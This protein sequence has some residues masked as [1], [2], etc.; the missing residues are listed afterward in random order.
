[1]NRRKQETYKR[2][3][4]LLIK[5]EVQQAE[6]EIRRFLDENV[7]DEVGLNLLSHSLLKQN[8][9]DKAM[10]MFK[11]IIQKYPNS[12]RA[13][14]DLG[15]LYD[16][17]GNSKEAIKSYGKALDLEPEYSEIWHFLGNLLM[18]K[19]DKEQGLDCF[20][21][22]FYYDPYQDEIRKMQSAM[23]AQNIKEASIISAQVLERHNHHPH[24]LTVMADIATGAGAHQDAQKMLRTGLDYSPYNLMLWF[25]LVSALGELGHHEERIE[26]AQKLFELEPELI[27][28]SA[29]LGDT[30]ANAGLYDKALEA[31]AHGLKIDNKS[32]NTLLQYG[33]MLK[34]LGRREEC[35]QAYRNC[36]KLKNFNGAV[37]WALADL[38]NS[39]F[40]AKD[41]EAMHDIMVDGNSPAAQA[42]QAGFALGKSYE[43]MQDFDTAFEYYA[44]ANALKPKVMFDVNNFNDQNN[45]IIKTF[46]QTALNKKAAQNSSPTP[47]FIIGL[48]RAG[49][50]LVEQILASHSLI[51]GTKELD[52]LPLIFKTINNIGRTKAIELPETIKSLSEQDLC[53][54]GQQYLDDTAIYRSGKPYFIDKLPSNFRFVGLIHMIL[55]NAIIF[56]VRRHPLD[57]GFSTYKQHFATGNDFSYNLEHIGHYYNSYLKLM[58]Y[59]DQV[60]PGKVYCL[61]YE[62]LVK[63]TEQEVQRLLD[64][65]GL[66]FEKNCLN[67]HKNKRAV[68]TPSS[69][70]VRQPITNKS[71]GYWR[72]FE[73]YLKPMINALGQETLKR[74]DD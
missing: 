61:Q 32:A 29:L 73:K 6:I 50:T 30:L 63:N 49:S 54:L 21:K 9:L 24:A 57:N 13:N 41:I 18:E 34:T 42:S 45:K 5:G 69:E 38:K 43:D 17:Q 60:L 66:T 19:G 31:Y 33:H 11:H 27:Q 10:A 40:T 74:F 53:D 72:N 14:A 16:R 52:N 22:S 56:D 44:Q 64:H 51:E 65:C 47:I 8:K 36:L 2:L 23:Q 70:Q 4:N 7:D 3:Q 26:A 71:I 62:K 59:W 48:P 12:P 58:D 68:N 67:F 39:K 15:I 20:K 25:K 46:S 55:P 35:E 1:M 28:T 37:Y